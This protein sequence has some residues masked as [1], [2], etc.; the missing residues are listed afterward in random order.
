M[1]LF[2]KTQTERCEAREKT[3]K[4]EEGGRGAG[5]AWPER[6]ATRRRRGA[7]RLPV[8]ETS[9]RRASACC[10]WWMAGMA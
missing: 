1:L 8:L 9:G 3:E 4:G 7:P 10:Y 5:T 2:E 6:L